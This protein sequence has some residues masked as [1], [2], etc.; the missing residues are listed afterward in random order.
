MSNTSTNQRRPTITPTIFDEEIQ[1][2]CVEFL[3]L[4]DAPRLG[5]FLA[6]KTQGRFYVRKA[7]DTP[8]N[9]SLLNDTRAWRTVGEA[10]GY[11]SASAAAHVLIQEWHDDW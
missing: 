11:N 1:A 2:Q 5:R 9:R 10:Q 7:P 6:V 3:E 4:G 8:E